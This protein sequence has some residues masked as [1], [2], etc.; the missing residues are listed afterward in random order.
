MELLNKENIK[1][2]NIYWCQME[3]LY[4]KKKLA[5]WSE[6]SGYKEFE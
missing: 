2:D 6:T 1:G 4:T 3:G 5:K